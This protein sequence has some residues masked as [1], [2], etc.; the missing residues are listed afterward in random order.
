M[1]RSVYCG[2]TWQSLEAG[3]LVSFGDARGPWILEIATVASLLRD[4]RRRRFSGPISVRSIRVIRFCAPGSAG[5]LTGGAAQSASSRTERP[6]TV[7]LGPNAAF[8]R[9]GTAH[10]VASRRAKAASLPPHSKWLSPEEKGTGAF[11]AMA[12]A[13]VRKK[14]PVPFTFTI[15]I[16]VRCPELSQNA[17]SS[18]VTLQGR[19]GGRRVR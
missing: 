12:Q 14:A 17:S 3:R 7:A 2:A 13:R 16:Y 9:G 11:T 19:P 15:S 8:T 18:P 4:D 5:P 1:T 6:R 10:S